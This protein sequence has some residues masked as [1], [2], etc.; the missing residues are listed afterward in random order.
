[1]DARPRVAADRPAAD[2][3]ETPSGKFRVPSDQFRT[4][5]TQRK[6]RGYDRRFT[7]RSQV[8]LQTVLTRSNSPHAMAPGSAPGAPRVDLDPR[9]AS[10]L[11]LRLV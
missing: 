10:L 5:K 9:L 8:K 6:R 2:P 11:C 7:P 4:T 1:M 3:V